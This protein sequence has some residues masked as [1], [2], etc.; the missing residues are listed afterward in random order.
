M[1]KRKELDKD[2]T[3]LDINA[4]LPFPSIAESYDEKWKTYEGI[5]WFRKKMAN[6]KK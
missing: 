1:K 4:P 2:T 6:E 3:S 5:V